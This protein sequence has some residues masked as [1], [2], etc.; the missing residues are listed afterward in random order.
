MMKSKSCILT[1]DYLDKVIETYADEDVNAASKDILSE[2]IGKAICDG[3]ATAGESYL[4][5]VNNRGL[6]KRKEQD[7]DD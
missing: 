5:S 2:I 4:Y 7:Y 3:D 6:K 1:Q